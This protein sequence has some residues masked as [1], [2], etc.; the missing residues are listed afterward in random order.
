MDLAS[1]PPSNVVSSLRRLKIPTKA[2]RLFHGLSASP[3]SEGPNKRCSDRTRTFGPAKIHGSLRAFPPW[4]HCRPNMKRK[5]TGLLQ[6][7]Q[8]IVTL[9]HVEI[10]WGN[11]SIQSFIPSLSFI[12]IPGKINGC[13]IEFPFLVGGFNPSEMFFRQNEN[14]PQIGVKIKN[15]WNHHLAMVAR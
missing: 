6:A 15:L 12:H 11:L 3:H 14:L 7:F 10:C 13:K 2:L 8:E 4:D 5:E 9:Y 1:Q